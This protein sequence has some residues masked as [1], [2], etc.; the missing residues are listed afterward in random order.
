MRLLVV[1][2]CED[3]AGEAL[4]LARAQGWSGTFTEFEARSSRSRLAPS[5][6]R[7]FFVK[8]QV[9]LSQVVHL[10]VSRSPSGGPPQLE[11]VRLGCPPHAPLECF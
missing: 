10:R 1:A 9:S 7:T 8:V 6:R 5:G 2:L 11:A 3:L 4:R